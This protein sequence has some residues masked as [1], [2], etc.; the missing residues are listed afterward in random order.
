MWLC[1]KSTPPRLSGI[2]LLPSID[3]FSNTV[4]LGSFLYSTIASTQSSISFFLSQSASP[5][6]P[7]RWRISFRWAWNPFPLEGSLCRVQKVIMVMGGFKRIFLFLLDEAAGYTELSIGTDFFCRFV[8]LRCVFI[9]QPLCTMYLSLDCLSNQ[10]RLLEFAS[11]PVV[12]YKRSS[13]PCK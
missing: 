2:L 13:N 10:H 11:T 1:Y 4:F 5:F 9:T 6:A 12:S 7:F 8:A 3:R